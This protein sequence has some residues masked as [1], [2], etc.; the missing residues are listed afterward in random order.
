MVVLRKYGVATHI[1]V[2]IVK[3]ASVDF[4][5]SADWTPAAG[6]VK[7][8]KDGGA[9]ANIGTLPAAIA[10]GNTAMW[11]FTI[12]ATE[13]QAA[14]IVIT[15]ADSATKAVEDQMILIDTYAGSSAEHA[16]D[17]DDGVRAGL[18]ALPNAAADAAGGLPISDAGGLDLDTKLANTHEI[19]AA[20]MGALTDWINGG[21]LDLILDII[22]ADTTTDIPATLATIAAYIDTEVAAILAAVDT[23]VADIRTRVLLALPNAAPDAAGGL[24]ISDAGGL[25]MDSIRARVILALPNA[26]PDAAGGLPVSDA[27]ALDIDTL[28][29]RLDAAITTRATPAQVNAE[30]VDA[31]NVD[32][33]AELSAVPNATPTL[34][35]ML[36]LMFMALKNKVTTT[37]SELKVHKDNG[38]DVLSTQAVSDDGSTFTKA[39]M[40]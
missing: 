3:R 37:G 5:V 17:L 28:L 24:P 39:K 18:T 34:R 29:A 30:V 38:T 31:L 33:Y 15:V 14:K 12:S 16:I 36:Q 32:T 20:R 6:D 8:S 27:G 22:A 1:Y 19:T 26:A 40:T 23:E 4:A 2:P 35:Q 9:A 13:M 7:I 21:R 25:D 10:M 11:D